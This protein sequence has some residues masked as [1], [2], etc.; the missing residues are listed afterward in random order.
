[1]TLKV[2]YSNK[3]LKDIKLAKKRHLNTSLLHDVIE[4]LRTG[5]KLPE[6]YHDP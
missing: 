6:K 4:M 1:M 2:Q 3:F 5:Q